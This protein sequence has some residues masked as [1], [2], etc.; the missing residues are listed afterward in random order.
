MVACESLLRWVMPAAADIPLVASA[1]MFVIW[2][3]EGGGSFPNTYN[4]GTTSAMD[5]WRVMD[6]CRPEA[7]TSLQP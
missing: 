4:H 3:R 2:K 6:G 7:A 5:E 1:G